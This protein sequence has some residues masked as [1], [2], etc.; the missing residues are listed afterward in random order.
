[1]FDFYPRYEENFAQAQLIL[2]MM[3]MGATLAP[4]DFVAVV[5][6]PRSLFVGLI[7]QIFVLP[8]IAIALN[9]WMDLDPGIALGLILVSAMPGGS[10]SK[11][12]A[13]LGKANVPLA[14]SLT[15]TTTLATL[16]T[17]PLM[18]QWLA[19][20]YMPQTFQM[21]VGKILTDVSLFLLAPLAG[22]MAFARLHPSR[23]KVFSE[24]CVRLGL[25]VVVV[26]V[27]A[28]LG[29]GRISPG[30][31]GWRAPIAIILFAV[32]SMQVNML[33]FRIFGW[34]SQDALAAGIV[35]TMRNMN[36]A[37]LLASSVFSKEDAIEPQVMFV[38]LF[39]AG[40]AMGAGAPLTL[41]YRYRVHRDVA[42]KPEAIPTAER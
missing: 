17:V 23:A 13:Y 40:A 27:V 32:L 37:L 1:M 6:K 5:Q 22:G 4:S 16:A 14:I 34:S 2:F 9:R 8:W 41:R 33:P 20:D 26:I 42:T 15:L 35:A 36:L 18:L 21:P 24:I 39:Y 10:L 7:G 28:S 3:G 38:V 19:A 29:S 25:V 31:H 30:A 12:F 11:V